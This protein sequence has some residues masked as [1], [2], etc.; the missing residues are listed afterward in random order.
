MSWTHTGDST[1]SSTTPA[2]GGTA[3]V[4]DMTD[5]QWNAVL[6]VT[7]TG[8]FLCMRAALRHLDRAGSRGRRQQRVGP[9][10]ASPGWT[11]PLRGREGRRHGADAVRRVEVAHAGVRVNAVAPS[12]AMHEHLAKVD[13]RRAPRELASRE[14]FG[15]AAEPWEVANVI[16][17]LA[18]DYS[19]Y[20][21]GEVLSVSSQHP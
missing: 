18:S 7:L 10:L 5:E 3:N 21:T 11:G 6:G 1:W 16:V 17:F 14:A 19:S 9:R 13:E 8:T 4:V 20:M 15:R 2:L 12:I